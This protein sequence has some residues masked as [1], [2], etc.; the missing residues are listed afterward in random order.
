MADERINIT[1]LRK[2][3][4]KQ[5]SLPEE[6]AS[7]F[8]AALFPAILEG[9]K[10]DKSVR[11]S[12][13]GVFKLV[14]VEPRKSVNINTGESIMLEG[15]NKLTFQP[16]SYI[17][18][19]INEP[20]AG[21]EAVR[22]DENGHPLDPQS[23]LP[24]IDPRVRFG[25]QADEIKGILADLGQDTD[26]TELRNYG[27][28]E[29]PDV[30]KNP[31]EQDTPQKPEKQDVEEK[32]ARESEKV[33][34]PS[35]KEDEKVASKTKEDKKPAENVKER[36][37]LRGWVI[38]VVTI[39]VLLVMLVVGY[40]VLVNKLENWADS[41]GKKA[42]AEAVVAEEEAEMLEMEFLQP[43]D[44]AGEN[45]NVNQNQNEN[46]NANVNDNQNQNENLNENLDEGEEEVFQ[47]TLLAIETVRSGSRLAQISRKY[48]GTPDH[49]EDIY[50]ANK[51]VI[52]DPNHLKSGTKLKIPKLSESGK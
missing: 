31:E 5:M 52:D 6:T 25:E 36:K 7:K 28:T 8:L 12:G 42:Q 47:P 17:R 35:T 29:K 33:V 39:A 10:A 44:S 26:S 49:W 21:L 43:M 45:V 3:I 11:I 51:D 18:E 34:V 30:E 37:P 23:T 4:S 24:G 2:A 40:F 14:W 20:F 27:V 22:V 48:Y 9:L 16:E 32:A 38:A 15:Y 19:Q 50:E 13:L 1:D 46:P 41:L